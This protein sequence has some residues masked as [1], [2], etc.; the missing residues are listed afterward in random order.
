VNYND[1]I[2]ILKEQTNSQPHQYQ[3]EFAITICKRLYPEYLKFFELYKW[4]N[5]EFLLE[6]IKL[7]EL[8]SNADSNID[9]IKSFLPKLYS[10]IPHMDDFGDEIGSYALNAS[11]AV[12]ETL[13]YILDKDR[14]HIFNIANYFTDTIDF[15]IQEDG[16]LT[17]S[18]IAENP[19][20]NEAWNF[21]LKLTK[22]G[23]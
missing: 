23:T 20:M 3:L 10:V 4:G 16:E 18:E 1:Y 21:I 14:T 2:K 8:S 5:P 17:D 7:C 11:A 22:K 12:H 6:G 9:Q 15:K 13:E 19:I